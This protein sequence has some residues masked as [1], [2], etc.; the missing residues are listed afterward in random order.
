MKKYILIFALLNYFGLEVFAQKT[1]SNL[2][3][4]IVAGNFQAKTI[5]DSRSMAD[6]EFYARMNND[7]SAILRFAYKTG[8]LVDTLFSAKSARDCKFEKFQG[9]E[10]SQDES[11]VL[12]YRNKIQLFRRS[13]KADYFVFER[14][15]NIIYPL[16]SGGMQQMATFSPNGRMVA[17]VRDANMCLVKLDYGTESQIT[18]DGE[19]NKITYG[20]PDWVYEEEFKMTRAFEWS[21]DNNFVAF[22]R[23]D[24][25]K[26]PEYSYTV[27]KGTNPSKNE[28]STYPGIEKI[29]YPKAGQPNS[30][31]SVLSFNVATKVVKIMELN[32]SEIEY[33]P[34]IQFTPQPDRLAVFTLNRQQN[35][36]TIYTANPRSGVC[37]LLISEENNTYVDNDNFDQISF[38]P[39]Q[40][41]VMSEKDGYRHLYDYS[42]TGV[43]RRQITKGSWEVTSFLGY[44]AATGIY[45]YESNKESPLRNGVYSL[46]GKG[47]ET[48]LTPN[49]GTNHGE[50]S[51][52]F[53]YFINVFS[54]A[55]TPPITEIKDATTGKTLS[56]LEANK[57]LTSKLT[58]NNFQTKE[59]FTFKNEKGILLNGWLIKPQT[60][61]TQKQHPVV[62]LQYNGPRSQQVKD[63]W[64][65]DWEQHLAQEGYVVACVD[66]RG[67][68]GRGEQFG[69]LT[70]GKLGILEAEDQIDAAHY[71]STLPY[72][73]KSKIAIWG[74][75]YGAYNVL[76]SMSLGKGV[77]K[78][79]IAVAPVTDWRL[80][81]TVYA[82]RYMR[83]PSE[84]AEGYESSSAGRYAS[85]LEGNLLLVQGTADDNVHIQNAYEYSEQLVQA[86]KPFDMQIY[87]NRNHFLKGGNTRLHLY[88]RFM[89]FLEQNL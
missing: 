12:I 55:K 27:F 62:M 84:N 60:F 7:S 33:I 58:E 31:V 47:K 61:D 74:W 85:Q 54:N 78:A 76:M 5:Q 89:R 87:T 41:V 3:K 65:M 70:Y 72:I 79:G 77:F 36:F 11:K 69:K 25:T 35:K 23:F 8:K 14:V 45:Y 29:K 80:Y 32:D 82:E 57:D 19:A 49:Q 50:L 63:E 26:V 22:L 52:N 56:I 59:F 42:P 38:Y 6:G 4:N 15:R 13:F 53:R 51:A 43:L 37:R 1:N 71:L 64:K 46:D 16:S 10:F 88:Q 67:T 40:I 9:F 66:G 48:C 30:E 68:S 17:F 39:D 83:T 81:D 2:L 18:K 21:P 73:N 20:M 28:Q 75:S 34:R 44:N 24:Q 86:G